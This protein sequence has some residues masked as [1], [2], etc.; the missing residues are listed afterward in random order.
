MKRFL[1]TRRKNW[2]KSFNSK[3]KN[4]KQI[5]TAIERIL[6]EYIYYSQNLKEVKSRVRKV[7][8]T[9][10]GQLKL[11]TYTRKDIDKTGLSRIKKVL[12]KIRKKLR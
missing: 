12:E 5:N 11:I 6:N 9:M 7:L 10:E 3:I 2:K 8:G 1:D 4:S